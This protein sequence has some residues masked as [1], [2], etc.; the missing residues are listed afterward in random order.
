VTRLVLPEH[1]AVLASG[2]PYID[3]V[4]VGS[5]WVIT[6]GWWEHAHERVRKL[7]NDPRSGTSQS[8]TRWPEHTCDVA[9]FLQNLAMSLGGYVAIFTGEFAQFPEQLLD[10]YLSP[11]NAGNRWWH[12]T[13]T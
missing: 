5:P 9:P 8:W 6:P 11:P 7:I 4:G 3:V 10:R 13:G 2:Q 12:A 1:L